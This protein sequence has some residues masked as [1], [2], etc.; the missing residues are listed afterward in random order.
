[1]SIVKN[2]LQKVK[3]VQPIEVAEVKKEPVVKFV[4][5]SHAVGPDSCMTM[6][7]CPDITIEFCGTHLHIHNQMGT[8][9]WCTPLS[10]VIW[11]KLA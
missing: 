6:R 2:A 8:V 1:M 7:S 10:N 3:P 11:W 4:Q 9:S 5:F